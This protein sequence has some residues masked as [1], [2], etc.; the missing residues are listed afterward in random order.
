MRKKVILKSVIAS[1]LASFLLLGT[2]PAHAKFSCKVKSIEG[3][4]LILK[5]C[6]EKGLK[7][8]KP[9][10]TVNITKKRKKAK[11]KVEGC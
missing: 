4:Q 8:L 1:F 7:K 9:G 10:D 3:D 5:K 6:Q 2:Y 11:A